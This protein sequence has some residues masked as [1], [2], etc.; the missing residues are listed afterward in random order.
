M[1]FEMHVRLLKIVKRI[2]WSEKLKKHI[3]T[4]KIWRPLHNI[5]K[6][7]YSFLLIWNTL[8]PKYHH[9]PISSCFPCLPWLPRLPC[10]SYL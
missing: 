8:R 7:L 6:I 4:F 5:T 3:W 10:L 2:L 9:A 1:T